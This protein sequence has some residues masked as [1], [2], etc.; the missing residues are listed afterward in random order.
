[1]SHD[2]DWAADRVRTTSHHPPHFSSSPGEL[3]GEDP[4]PG[5]GTQKVDSHQNTQQNTA[6][7]DKPVQ[8]VNQHARDLRVTGGWGGVQEG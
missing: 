6:E 1:M 8:V 7:A 2:L 5:A 3:L 4:P